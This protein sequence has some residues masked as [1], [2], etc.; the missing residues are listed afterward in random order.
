MGRVPD[1]VPVLVPNV[2]AIFWEWQFLGLGGEFQF[3]I[4]F[5]WETLCDIEQNQHITVKLCIASPVDPRLLTAI[6]KVVLESARLSIAFNM[7]SS[8]YM[9]SSVCV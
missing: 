6:S 7:S 2:V 5:Q 8:D 9:L 3:Q 4:Q 1:P